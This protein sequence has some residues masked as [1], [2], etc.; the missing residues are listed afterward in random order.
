MEKPILFDPKTQAHLIPSFVHIHKSCITSPPYTI[1]TFLPPLRDD[2]MISWWQDRCQ[3]VEKGERDIIMQMALNEKTE[4]NE[5]AGFVMLGKPFAETGPFRGS[6]EK[7]L[8]LPEYRKRGIARALM[9]RLEE[10]AK[11]EGRG[12]LTLVTEV[13][14]P[15]EL[16]YPRLGYIEIGVVPKDQVSPVDGSLKDGKFFYKD[17][18][19][20]Q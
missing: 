12:L 14:S 3:E 11:A 10:V 1:A 15:A 13:G 18:R 16:V 9:L 5:L 2:K 19:A 17:L 6:V 7:L 8:V 20:H 4:E